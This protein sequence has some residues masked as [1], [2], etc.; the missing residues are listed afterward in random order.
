MLRGSVMLGLVGAMLLGASA[1]PAVE[2]AAAAGDCMRPELLHVFMAMTVSSEVAVVS[3]ETMV[4]EQYAQSKDANQTWITVAQTA[5]YTLEAGI[6]QMM[7]NMSDPNVCVTCAAL[8]SNI[9]TIT[10]QTAGTID[11]VVPG[12]RA[13]PRCLRFACKRCSRQRSCC[14]GRSRACLPR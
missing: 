12:V 7:N 10:K 8:A 6:A 5:E 3:A 14:S 4:I 1:L 13:I 11:R 9:N 2:V